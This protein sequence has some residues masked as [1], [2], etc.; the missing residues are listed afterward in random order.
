MDRSHRQASRILRTNAIVNALG[1]VSRVAGDA[2]FQIDDARVG[3]PMGQ[4]FQCSAPDVREIH[5]ARNRPIHVLR[6]ADIIHCR[7]NVRLV[8]LRP[9]RMRQDLIDAT[10]EHDV[11]TQ[12]DTHGMWGPSMVQRSY[13]PVK[14]ASA[15]R[16]RRASR[17]TAWQLGLP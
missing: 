7:L 12:K 15:S 14:T 6:K 10:S 11:A 5:V 8:K 1:F 13:I 17:A 4:L 2:C 9:A 3:P 16:C